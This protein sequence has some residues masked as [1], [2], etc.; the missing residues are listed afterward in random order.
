MSRALIATSLCFTNREPLRAGRYTVKTRY[1]QPD[2]PCYAEQID[3][4]RIR[5]V[6][7]HDVAAVTP[8][9]SAVLYNGDECLGGGIIE[10]RLQ[11]V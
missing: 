2:I 4:D 10:Q 7:D 5:V 6:F 8:G 11:N 3:D 9:Q 1:R